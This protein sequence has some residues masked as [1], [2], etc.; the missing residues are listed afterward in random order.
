M[1]FTPDD[2]IRMFPA[3]ESEMAK[4]E[5]EDEIRKL[6]VSS[7]AAV[8]AATEEMKADFKNKINQAVAEIRLL[9]DV[10][11]LNTRPGTGRKD[12]FSI[13]EASPLGSS[14]KTPSPIDGKPPMRRKESAQF[15]SLAL[16]LGSLPTV[17]RSMYNLHGVEGSVGTRALSPM[18][19]LPAAAT[20]VIAA[21]PPVVPPVVAPAPP[22]AP[23][24]PAEPSEEVLQL[25]KEMEA[26][27]G[28]MKDIKKLLGNILVK[29]K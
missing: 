22:A 28:D 2:I 20:P 13:P 24:S 6:K 7:E 16:P 17:A 26:L 10:L 8:T 11:L 27:K 5:I 9:K 3:N 25:Q 21:T 14:R 19:R 29:M 23:A 15:Q 12:S 1:L 18:T 4:L